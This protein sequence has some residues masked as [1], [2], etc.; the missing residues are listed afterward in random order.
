M[1]QAIATELQ[2]APS[3]GLQPSDELKGWLA[4]LSPAQAKGIIRIVEAEMAGETVESLLRGTR[5]I[6]SRSTFYRERG[7]WHNRKFRAALDLARK[8]IRAKTMTSALDEAIDELKRTTPLAARDLRRQIVGD[9][10][11]IDA[12]MAVIKDKKASKENVDERSMA[13]FSLSQIGTPRATQALLELMSEK[14]TEVRMAVIKA[15][16]TSAAG[17]NVQRRLA[18]IAVLDRA[19]KMTASKGATIPAEELDAEIE[20]EMARLRGTGDEET[21]RQGDK[22]TRGQGDKESGRSSE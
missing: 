14:N 1:A 13:V 7:W 6:C 4:K 9:E 8:E 16:G 18:D 15:I 2:P 12:L 19:D 10:P 17:V 11:A 22:E 21:R 3:S 5:K 20:R